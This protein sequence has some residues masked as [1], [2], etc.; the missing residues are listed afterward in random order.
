MGTKN[1]R[2]AVVYPHDAP[3]RWV[4]RIAWTKS[5]I[6]RAYL[7]G[8]HGIG[9]PLIEARIV[10]WYYAAEFGY[11]LPPT[12]E[13][14]HA[15]IK[16]EVGVLR[17]VC[18]A[19]IKDLG[20]GDDHSARIERKCARAKESLVAALAVLDGKR[21]S[22]AEAKVFGPD[23]QS[24]AKRAMKMWRKHIA[25]SIET[26]APDEEEYMLVPASAGCNRRHE[27][28]AQNANAISMFLRAKQ[29]CC[30]ASTASTAS[31]SEYRRIRP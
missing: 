30:A 13:P 11:S 15:Q 31:T 6:Q 2:I 27:R 25:P 28:I 9:K 5:D 16:A 3:V 18:R 22:V 29:C 24:R 12:S 8:D 4:G 21:P 23:G 1:I 26:N 19:I 7:D 14:V 10:A 17:R 20:V